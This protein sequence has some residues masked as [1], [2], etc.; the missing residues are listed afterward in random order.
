MKIVLNQE[1]KSD[2]SVVI[3]VKL[4]KTN[5]RVNKNI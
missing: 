3:S 2:I 1:T 5:K 4:L